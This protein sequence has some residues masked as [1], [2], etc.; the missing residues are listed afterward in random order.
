MTIPVTVKIPDETYKILEEIRRK[1]GKLSVP[2][3]IRDAISFYL[4]FK[5]KITIVNSSS[6]SHHSG[7]EGEKEGGVV[8]NE[9]GGD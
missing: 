7:E 6:S 3:V 9:E 4:E 8:Y 2:E 1:K 5:D